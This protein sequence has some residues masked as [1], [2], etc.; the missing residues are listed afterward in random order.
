MTGARVHCSFQTLV[1]EVGRA[2]AHR[3]SR[4]ISLHFLLKNMCPNADVSSGEVIGGY[5]Y[6]G[7]VCV[8]KEFRKTRGKRLRLDFK[9]RAT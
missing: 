7:L 2:R 6:F 8:Y 3:G 9:T 1:F 4:G 5:P